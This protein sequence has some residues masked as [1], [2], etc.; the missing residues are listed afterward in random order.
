MNGIYN[1]WFWTITKLILK[2]NNPIYPIGEGL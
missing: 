2:G 1:M